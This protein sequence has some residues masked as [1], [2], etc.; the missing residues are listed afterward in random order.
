MITSQILKRYVEIPVISS[1]IPYLNILYTHMGPPPRLGPA[2]K[3]G[4]DQVYY[5]L[6]CKT[7]TR[8]NMIALR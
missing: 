8:E 1:I 3:S 5:C 4:A 2:P 6:C 7:F